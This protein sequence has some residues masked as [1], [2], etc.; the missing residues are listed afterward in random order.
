MTPTGICRQTIRLDG[1]F[2]FVGRSDIVMKYSKPFL[3]PED[4]LNLL[5]A[6]GLEV[7]YRPEAIANLSR[8]GYYR[9]SGYW[10]Q[11]RVRPYDHREA[12]DTP[13]DE[14]VGGHS[15]EEAVDLYVFDRQL[16]LLILDAIE[17]VEVALRVAISNTV[18]RYGPLAYLDASFL[19]PG[20]FKSRSGDNDI[21]N[22]DWFVQRNSKLLSDSS[23][24]FASHVK[25]KYDGVPP[26][27][28]ATE[29]W[30]WG[31]L[32]AFYELMTVEDRV[33]V[34]NF[35]GV[36]HYE[37]L[38]SWIKSLNYLRNLCA[39]HSRLYRKTMVTKPSTK[40]MMRIPELR[41]V[42]TSPIERQDKLYKTLAALAYL[43]SRIA[44]GSS[45]HGRLRALTDSF[46]KIEGS[47]LSDYGFPDQWRDECLWN[48]TNA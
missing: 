12:K 31:I 38:N 24:A 47:S 18:G 4:L 10:Y 6:R 9:L 21:S 27:W 22:F 37:I 36:P 17:R 45:W 25:S 42:R 29:C 30:D 16:R 5:I 2:P 48:S 26:L 3:P 33:V 11:W 7:D 19:G 23:E 13:L 1:V 20:C 39:H 14:F 41:H 35:F 28:I 46:P 34:A 44:P 15:I 8:I 40:K 32:A 43:V